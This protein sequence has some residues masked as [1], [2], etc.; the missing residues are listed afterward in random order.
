MDDAPDHACR[1]RLELLA[2]VSH[3]LRN[4]L[5]SILTGTG[6]IQRLA[7][8]LPATDKLRRYADIIE[9][10]AERMNRWISALL[11][12]A[13][14]ESGETSLFR[15]PIEARAVIHAA[16]DQLAHA[17]ATKDVRLA[18][19]VRNDPGLISVD[20]ERM[21]QILAELIGN[22]IKFTPAG[23]RVTVAADRVDGLTVFSVSDTGPGIPPDQQPRLLDSYWETRRRLGARAGLGLPIARSL[24]EAH[25][26][27]LR[28]DSPAGSGAVFSFSVA[29]AKDEV[30]ADSSPV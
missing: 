20:R 19:E 2:I 11:E 5:G 28:C 26:G 8:D 23:G 16:V 3:D 18:A 13:S 9:R 12:L 30:A 14:I 29:N 21:L 10:A 24:V 15:T 6:L 25:G 22:A 4:P 27:T 17:A 1:A 7:S